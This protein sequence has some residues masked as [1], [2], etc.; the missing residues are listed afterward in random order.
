M[1]N[2][3]KLFIT[4][5]DKEAESMKG[6]DA[7]IKGVLIPESGFL[8]ITKNAPF[9][10]DTVTVSGKVVYYTPSKSELQGR[11]FCDDDRGDLG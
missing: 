10:P 6:G 7:Q 4:L 9:V 2:M 11:Y 3:S 5:S 1:N 8:A